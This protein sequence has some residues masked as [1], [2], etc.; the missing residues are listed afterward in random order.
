MDG[1]VKKRGQNLD[2]TTRSGFGFRAKARGFPISGEDFLVELYISSRSA[3]AP[4]LHLR[5]HQYTAKPVLQDLGRNFDLPPD[6]RGSTV[7]GEA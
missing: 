5:M 3:Y 1:D 6:G 4:F 7:V 2:S